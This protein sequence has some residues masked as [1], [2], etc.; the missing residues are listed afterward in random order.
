[1][2]KLTCS[3]PSTEAAVWKALRYMWE[4]AFTN[5]RAN[6]KGAG[7]YWSFLHGW[8]TSEMPFKKILPLPSWP[9][10]GRYHF[11]LFYHWGLFYFIFCFLGL[12][13]QHMEVPILGVKLEL[14]LPT[15]TT[16]TA[17][18]DLSHV[19]DLHHSSWQCWILNPMREAKDWM[20]ILMNTSWVHYHWVRTGTPILGFLSTLL[21]LLAL[22]WYY[23]M[24]LPHPIH[25]SQPMYLQRSS[26]LVISSRQSQLIWHPPKQLLPCHKW[27][28]SAQISTT[29]LHK[30]LSTKGANP[31]HQCSYNCC[32]CIHTSY[33]S[34]QTLSNT[35]GIFQRSG[36][37][38]SKICMEPRKT[39]SS[40]KNPWE[41]KNETEVSCFLASNCTTNL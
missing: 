2:H 25:P 4:D 32:S 37:N 23:S 26:S 1:M 7:I 8:S 13:L 12:H 6:A 38:N 40:Q 17:T 21:A 41:K 3:E 22:P 16:A 9:G 34:M 10:A 11:G 30:G 31:A 35:K 20:L 27:A 36:I 39:M 29:P 15:Y 19:C 24:D 28:A 33:T 14:Q 5:F 18:W